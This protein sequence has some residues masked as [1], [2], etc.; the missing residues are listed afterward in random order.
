MKKLL[1]LALIATVTIVTSCMKDINKRSDVHEELPPPPQPVDI[2]D[3]KDDIIVISKTS[4][5]DH[6][7]K[8]YLMLSGLKNDRYWIGI[9]DTIDKTLGK[10]KYSKYYEWVG[11]NTVK[12]EKSVDL[13]YQGIEEYTLNLDYYASIRT[14]GIGLSEDHYIFAINQ[15]YTLPPR[16]DKWVGEARL[17]IVKGNFVTTGELLSNCVNSVFPWHAN[18][19]L[20]RHYASD[21]SY[22][23]IYDADGNFIQQIIL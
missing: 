10:E 21:V 1:L 4:F 11:S 13:G 2:F 18:T 7:G 23:A 6:L 22:D 5:T 8:S 20:V 12:K 14:F 15:I 19:I 16:G 17:L 9:A 3:D